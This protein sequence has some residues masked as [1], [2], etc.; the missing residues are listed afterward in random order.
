MINK[1]ELI[2]KIIDY[3]NDNKFPFHIT[4]FQC[5][6]YLKHYVKN[7]KWSSYK[8]TVP[9]NRYKNLDVQTSF[10]L[11][12]AIEKFYCGYCCETLVKAA[13]VILNYDVKPSNCADLIRCKMN[14]K[15][16]DVTIEDI[17]DDNISFCWKIKY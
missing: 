2:G 14:K 3:L 17:F 9:I 7:K 5:F 12:L 1:V 6:D 11:K 4:K 15:R 13:L 16:Y 10:G 8:I